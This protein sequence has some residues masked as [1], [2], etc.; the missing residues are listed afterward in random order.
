[1][2]DLNRLKIMSIIDLKRRDTQGYG[3]CG[4]FVTIQ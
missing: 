2:H 4:L 1:M 3:H